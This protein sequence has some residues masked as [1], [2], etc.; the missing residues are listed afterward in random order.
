MSNQSACKTILC[1]STCKCSDKITVL[2]RSLMP[3]LSDKAT[4]MI[5]FRRFHICFHITIGNR[6]SISKGLSDKSAC[7]TISALGNRSN[8][9]DIFDYGTVSCVTEK[10]D[11]TIYFFINH[12]IRNCMTVSVQNSCKL[13]NRLPIARQFNIRCQTII[14]IWLHCT[15]FFFCRN[16]FLFCFNE[17]R[18]MFTVCRIC[19]SKFCVCHSHPVF[20]LSCDRCIR[21][22][23]RLR[24]TFNHSV[25]VVPLIRKRSSVTYRC[26]YF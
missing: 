19:N 18:C 26:Y 5:P 21:H 6:Q 16:F 24:C 11:W 1:T 2:N 13:L 20:H 14:S 7:L 9:S 15:Q 10:A 3:H 4:H 25:T 22:I 8:Q 23:G 12:Y 17:N